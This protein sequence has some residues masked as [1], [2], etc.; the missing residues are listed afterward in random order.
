MSDLFDNAPGPI[1]QELE[2]AGWRRVVYFGTPAWQSPE[3]RFVT[4]IDEAAL[5]VKRQQEKTTNADSL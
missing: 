3:G 5:A 2:A 1:A 4:T